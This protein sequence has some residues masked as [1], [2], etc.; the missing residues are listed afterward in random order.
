MIDSLSAPPRLF[1]LS[2]L[3]QLIA[4]KWKIKLA[5]CDLS[6]EKMPV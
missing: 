4:M 3:V 5:N 2:S 1:S 6:G